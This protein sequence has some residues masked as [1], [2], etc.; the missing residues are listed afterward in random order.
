[1]GPGGTPSSATQTCSYIAPP[2][3]HSLHH[4]DVLLLVLDK[5]VDE[6]QVPVDGF[7]A[8]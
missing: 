4:R 2:L 3:K 7:V 8:L 5:A 6:R 1:M